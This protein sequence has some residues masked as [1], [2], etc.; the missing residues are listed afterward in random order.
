VRLSARDL[1]PEPLFVSVVLA[2]SSEQL[3]L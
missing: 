1:R 2:R 3:A